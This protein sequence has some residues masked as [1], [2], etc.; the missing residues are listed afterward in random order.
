MAYK[1]GATGDIGE[2]APDS[3]ALDLGLLDM[4]VLEGR[5]GIRI[6]LVNAALE[7][8]WVAALADYGLRPGAFT[9][10]ALI[11]ANP[12]CSQVAIAREGGL[13]KTALVATVDD[14]EARGYAIRQRD[15]GDRRRNSLFLT[16][17]GEALLREMAALPGA[18]DQAIHAALDAG[19]VEILLGLLTRLHRAVR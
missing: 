9:C 2:P 19:E 1:A 8:R 6:R 10:M 16:E 11:S 14:L 5:L 7:Q 4:G 15:A 13:E 3:R 17:A 12:G 18:S